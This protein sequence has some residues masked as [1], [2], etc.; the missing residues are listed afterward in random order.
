MRL[1]RISVLRRPLDLMRNLKTNTNGRMNGVPLKKNE[2]LILPDMIKKIG[3]RKK[4]DQIREPI[5]KLRE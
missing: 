2:D 1:G 5:R 4:I 3:L